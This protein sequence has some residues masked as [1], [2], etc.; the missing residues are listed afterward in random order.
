MPPKRPGSVLSSN[1]HSVKRRRRNKTL[2]ETQLKVQQA[3]KADNSH[4]LYHTRQFKQTKEN[5]AEKDEG[6]RAEML[7]GY[8]ASKFKLR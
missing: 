1:K 6:K 3:V 2:T 7:Q 8:L 5:K 4:K